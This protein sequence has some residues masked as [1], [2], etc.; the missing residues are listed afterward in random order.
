MNDDTARARFRRE[1]D[2]AR[3]ARHPL[4]VGF[5]DAGE[6]ASGAWIVME[7]VAGGP[8]SARM[9]RGPVPESEAVL[10]AADVAEVLADLHADGVVHRDVTPSNI[11]LADDGRARLG[12]FGIARTYDRAG[13]EDMTATGDVVG[14]FRF[15]APEV[16]AGEAASPS[17]DV[18]SLGAVLFEMLAGTPA[19][20]ASS[21]AALLASQGRPP[22]PLPPVD[23]SVE[24]T[25]RRMLSPNPEARPTAAAVAGV[26]ARGRSRSPLD[27]DL[28]V[29]MP[30]PSAPPS[31]DVAHAHSRAAWHAG[32]VIALASLLL[33]A[34]IL[35][36]AGPL[37]GDG[38]PDQGTA[39]PRSSPASASPM[40]TASPAPSASNAE[41]GT[42]SDGV[43]GK[44]K[45]KGKGKPGKGGG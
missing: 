26:L 10:I 37:S 18:W 33:G 42:S 44:G 31:V 29:V 23:A 12:D 30:A 34:V 13:P 4:A 43:K 24:R 28:T 1:T 41:K 16:L 7:H 35:L 2:A 11:L 19:F 17:S 20:D 40:P 45:G 5:R 14:T 27:D 36:A 6:D 38:A 8:L 32:P 25:V 22:P 3:S 9:R 21:P 15:L 39:E